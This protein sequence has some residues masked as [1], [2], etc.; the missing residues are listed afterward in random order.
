MQRGGAVGYGDNGSVSAG[1][2]SQARSQNFL[3]RSAVGYVLR[4][5]ARGQVFL[6]RMKIKGFERT[7]RDCS[8]TPRVANTVYVD[9][10]VFIFCMGERRLPFF[11]RGDH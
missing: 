2:R 9:V 11:H 5:N 3:E 1:H 8:F 4:S 7:P 10:F 6:K